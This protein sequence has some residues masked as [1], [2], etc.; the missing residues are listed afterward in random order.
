MPLYPAG[1]RFVPM[2]QVLL[3]DAL[4]PRST[5]GIPTTYLVPYTTAL[6]SGRTKVTLRYHLFSFS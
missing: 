5:G 1:L 3:P 4:M 2:K 6:S